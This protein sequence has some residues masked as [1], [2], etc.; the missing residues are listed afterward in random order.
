MLLVPE[1]PQTTRPVSGRDLLRGTPGGGSARVVP[2]ASWSAGSKSR[3]S[4]PEE[5]S[6]LQPQRRAGEVGGCHGAITGERSEQLG[7]PPRVAPCHARCCGVGVESV[8]AE[9]PG[10]LQVC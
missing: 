5:R 9:R 4:S 8:A 6:D 7:R 2:T 1:R 10:V 3:R